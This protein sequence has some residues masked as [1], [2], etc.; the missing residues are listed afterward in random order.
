MNAI[1]RSEA[2][3]S[4]LQRGFQDGTSKLTRRKCFGYDVGA[5]GEL[6][7]N[8]DEAAIVR[9]IFDQYLNGSSLG[10][11]AADLERKDILS[12]T[13]RPKWNRETLNKP[14]SNEKYT[15]WALLQK[16]VSAGG[17]QIK[18]DGFMER[19]LCTGFH[20]AIISDEVFQ[21]VQRKK[22]SRAKNPGNTVAA[23]LTF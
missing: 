6:I 1:K 7:V 5:D 17:S 3:R 19:Y 18:N 22:L 23:N 12:P 20:E 21:A 8:S 9:W 11:I 2:I 13:G 4:G 14:L 15:G 10:A 16:T